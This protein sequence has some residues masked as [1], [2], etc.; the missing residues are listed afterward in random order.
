MNRYTYNPGMLLKH[1]TKIE[2]VFKIYW[3]KQR[4]S[5]S[6]RITFPDLIIINHVF[7]FS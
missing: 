4:W 2:E 6:A 3:I 1:K 7:D 5:R